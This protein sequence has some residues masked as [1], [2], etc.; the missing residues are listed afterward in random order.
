MGMVDVLSHVLPTNLGYIA[1]YLMREDV[2]VEIWDFEQERFEAVEFLK[3][4]ED[5]SPRIVGISCMT[6][7]IINGHQ[8]ASLV[9]KHFPNIVTVVGG[10]HSSAMPEETLRE[11]PSF[12]LVVNQE[13]EATFLELCQRA[14]DGD[15][16]E[17]LV[18]ATYHPG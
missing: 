7:T 18:G 5:A 12:D 13:G 2:D 9:K 11:F 15:G 1:A 8:A 16:F 3:R 6:P 14:S 10:A 4:V 17:G